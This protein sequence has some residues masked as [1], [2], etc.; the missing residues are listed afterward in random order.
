M[1]KNL[2][3]NSPSAM[4]Y[5]GEREFA[6][7]A[8]RVFDGSRL[9]SGVAVVVK[10]GRISGLVPIAQVPPGTTVVSEPGCTIIPGLIDAHVHFARWQGPLY[11]AHGV[12]TIRD[13]GNQQAWI[14]ARRAEWSDHPWPRIFCVGPM[15]DGPTVGWVDLGR[16]C[17]DAESAVR[18]V[19]E[20]ASAGVD[21]IKLYDGLP[22]E[23]LSV[24]AAAAHDEGL[25]A[26]IHCG[27]S[28]VLQAATAGVDEFHHLDGV[29]AEFWPD[30][31]PGWL[32]VWGHPGC[33]STVAKQKE[34][35]DKIALSGMIA[36]PTLTYWHS[37]SISALPGYPPPEEVALM[38][39]K[40]NAWGKSWGTR[41]PDAAA[42]DTWKR[43]L[44]AAR[45]FTSL[46]IERDVPVLAGTDVPCE[47]ISP[48][49]SLWREMS[50]LADCGMSAE[51]ALRA[52][53]SETAKRLR[54]R[55]VG[56]L[57][58]GS[59]ADLSFVRGD[60]TSGIPE[61]PEVP[62]V[63]RS[64]QVHR[65]AELVSAARQEAEDFESEPLYVAF[66]RVAGLA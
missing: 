29:V 48:G 36:T 53:T 12:T 38:P 27:K 19:V 21:G 2:D 25:H 42:A 39:G 15:L 54:L 13:V 57:K 61:R 3:A 62:I 8:D 18:A 51:Q 32:E 30:H 45:A 46:L 50:L 10:A 58:Q 52:A 33:G 66:R 37:R 40:V 59:P 63:V 11:L 43:A 35:A 64:G 26:S 55:N 47:R 16:G 1:G 65:R 9:R 17:A 31:P 20:T 60:P 34:V 23:W 5:S 44:E 56:S 28:T 7:R 14:L 6:C 22:P 41:P 49:V 24:M 4:T